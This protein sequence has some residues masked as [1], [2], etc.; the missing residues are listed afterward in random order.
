MSRLS[1]LMM[2][3]TIFLIIASLL[4]TAF[5][6]SVSSHLTQADRYNIVK[7][8]FSITKFPGLG[9]SRFLL[10]HW[11]LLRTFPPFTTPSWALP[12]WEKPFQTVELYVRTLEPVLRR[13]MS[14]RFSRCNFQSEYGPVCN[15][16]CCQA[17]T[18]AASLGCPLTL[19]SEA[20]AA[21]KAGLSEGATTAS[22]YF[23]AKTQVC[24]LG[25][26]PL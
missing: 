19:S 14:R 7:K 6:T 1:T 2:H 15:M 8:K 22:I 24:S 20:A 13:P 10:P 25:Q 23:A 17:S 3:T 11:L 21:V 5:S 16:I 12:S 4:P 18:A 9:S 26:V